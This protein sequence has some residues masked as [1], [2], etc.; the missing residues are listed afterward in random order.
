[1]P[2]SL[3][4]LEDKILAASE[5]IQ[6]SL[7]VIESHLGRAPGV[8]FNLANFITSLQT[9]DTK[10]TELY[11]AQMELVGIE[12]KKI[13]RAEDVRRKAERLQRVLLA[14][15]DIRLQVRTARSARRRPVPA[16]VEAAPEPEPAA[17]EPE[18]HLSQ[19]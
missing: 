10:E 14:K 6:D 9:C 3:P 7:R 19:S 1:M 11:G 4:Q 12:I 15:E 16:D 18:P 13:M 17:P 8:S 2:Y 5:R